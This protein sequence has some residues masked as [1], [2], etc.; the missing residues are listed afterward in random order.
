MTT[1]LGTS[2]CRLHH[3]VDLEDVRVAPREWRH[4][5]ETAIHAQIAQHRQ[6]EVS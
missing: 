2:R 3:W 1:Y 4:L 6:Q 5:D